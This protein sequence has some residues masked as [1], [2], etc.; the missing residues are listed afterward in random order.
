MT[1][2]PD[3]NRSAQGVEVT[4]LGPSLQL[5]RGQGE[6]VLG[7]N[8]NQARQ[9]SSDLASFDGF[10]IDSQDNPVL[11]GQMTP[12]ANMARPVNPELRGQKDC[13]VLAVSVTFQGSRLLFSKGG[14]KTYLDLTIDQTQQLNEEFGDLI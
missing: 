12:V 13:Q 1:P 2:S 6:I 10:R 11:L 14:A 7:L 4:L 9:V 8:T 5:I 3:L